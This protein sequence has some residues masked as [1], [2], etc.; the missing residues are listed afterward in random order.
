DQTNQQ[1]RCANVDR[2]AEELIRVLDQ[3]RVD[4]PCGRDR[5]RKELVVVRNE[6]RQQP[7]IDPR[8]EYLAGVDE[9]SGFKSLSQ[10][11]REERVLV[12]EQRRRELQVER[13]RE[14]LIGVLDAR[15]IDRERNVNGEELVGVGDEIGLYLYGEGRAV[16]RILV[17]DERDSELAF[18]EPPRRAPRRAPREAPGVTHAA[19]P[20]SVPGC[21]SPATSTSLTYWILASTA[22]ASV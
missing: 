21:P 12:F 4:A 2:A 3:R 17:D 16:E 1:L 7:K 20:H 18:I 5:D 8:R 22:P 9:Q 15:W 13:R 14:E 6:R 11:R 19:G 10:G